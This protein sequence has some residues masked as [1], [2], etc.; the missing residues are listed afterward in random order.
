[1]GQPEE[2]DSRRPLTTN[3]EL[4]SLYKLAVEMADAVSARR[5][6]AN[7]FFSGLHAVLVGVLG[8]GGAVALNPVD[9]RSSSV[10][11]GFTI[12]ASVG[13]LLCGAWFLLLK[14]YRDLNQ[15]KFSVILRLEESLPI[16][17]FAE[18]WANLKNDPVKRWR[19][20]YAEFGDIE[21]LVPLF[22]GLVYVV[23]IVLI[24]Y[25]WA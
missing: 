10:A 17:L 3:G 14:S 6:T 4:V 2:A 11:V 19:D 15:A 9:G 13:L 7:A 1:M 5:G 16:Q 21:R 24:W 8:T 23:L 12:L 22:F 20:R 18:E 25:V